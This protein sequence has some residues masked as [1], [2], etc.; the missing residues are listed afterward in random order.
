MV[1]VCCLDRHLDVERPDIVPDH[2]TILATGLACQGNIEEHG[3]CAT[4]AV[5]GPCRQ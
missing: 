1:A 5:Q 3:P 4:G 2:Q